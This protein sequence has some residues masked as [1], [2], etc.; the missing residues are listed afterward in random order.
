MAAVHGAGKP[1]LGRSRSSDSRRKVLAFKKFAVSFSK[2]LGLLLP[3]FHGSQM[4]AW[5]LICLDD[6]GFSFFFNNHLLVRTPYILHI[7]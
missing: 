5:Y 7:A 6:C 4:R 3:S 1:Q 2:P